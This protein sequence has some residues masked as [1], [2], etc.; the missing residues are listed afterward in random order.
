M[1]IDWVDAAQALMARSRRRAG[2]AVLLS[3][4]L[5][6]SVGAEVHAAD[7]PPG[8]SAG[9]TDQAARPAP[10]IGDES[11]DRMMRLVIKSRTSKVTE[12]NPNYEDIER[13]CYELRPGIAVSPVHVDGELV[14]V[15]EQQ[16]FVDRVERWLRQLEKTPAGQERIRRLGAAD[17]LSEARTWTAQGTPAEVNVIIEI[18]QGGAQP[19]AFDGVAARDFRGSGTW[20]SMANDDYLVGFRTADGTEF[21]TTKA[22]ALFHELGH[23]E[24][25]L[26]GAMT[27]DVVTYEIPDP[28]HEAEPNDPAGPGRR[29]IVES[30]EEVVT[31]G[32]ELGMA[33]AFGQQLVEEG[34][35][36]GTFTI[37][38]P[39][40]WEESLNYVDDILAQGE[41]Y[42]H[43]M[44]GVSQQRDLRMAVNSGPPLTDQVYAREA[45]VPV[46][47]HY[48]F[49]MEPDTD[50]MQ[51][52]RAF[53]P[54]EGKSEEDLTGD[55][56]RNPRERL[57]VVP[58]SEWGDEG[59]DSWGTGSEACGF[60]LMCRA[61]PAERG[62]TATEKALAR[63]FES[64]KKAGTV[65]L[66]SAAD[67]M[68][69]RFTPEELAA[70]A[71]VKVEG[72]V[73]SGRSFEPSY[74]KSL[75]E[76]D[77]VLLTSPE[78]AEKMNALGES[79]REQARGIATDP[80][81]V[82]ALI[83]SIGVAFVQDGSDL[84]KA[85]TALAPVPVV[86]SI[87]GIVGD[88]QNKRSGADIAANVLNLIGGVALLA[89]QPEISLVLLAVSMFVTVI[90]QIIAAG[91]NVGFKDEIERRNQGW[92]QELPAYLRATVVPATVKAINTLFERMQTRLLA[93]TLMSIAMV[94]TAASTHPDD[95][96]VQQKAQ[97]TV[98]SLRDT[99]NQQAAVLRT[100]FMSSVGPVLDRAVVDLNAEE[101][102]AKF[103]NE[104]LAANHQRLY[105]EAWNEARDCHRYPSQSLEDPCG[106]ESNDSIA[107]RQVD[108]IER[109]VRG[110]KPPAFVASDLDGVVTRA[111]VDNGLFQAQ[112]LGEDLTEAFSG[113]ALSAWIGHPDDRTRIA[114]L[115]AAQQGADARGKVTLQARAR[116]MTRHG[117]LRSMTDRQEALWHWSYANP[118]RVF[119]SGLPHA[120]SPITP[121]PTQS[122]DLLKYTHA[123]GSGLPDDR[124]GTTLIGA[125]RSVKSGGVERV[126]TPD[127][128][129]TSAD[130]FW[131]Y[132]IHAPG[133]ID[134]TRSI[135]GRSIEDRHE[136]VFFGGIKREYVRAAR[137]IGPDGKVKKIIT[138]PGFV[139]PPDRGI[140]PRLQCT[141]SA[142]VES[143][144]A[145]N[146]DLD[147]RLNDA[148]Y[149]A[150]GAMKPLNGGCGYTPSA[151]DGESGSRDAGGVGGSPE[152]P[153]VP[154]QSAKS[155]DSGGDRCTQGRGSNGIG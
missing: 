109:T 91:K 71:R 92:T 70:Y 114:Q 13:L 155:A 87:L 21:A 8:G 5:V 57:R 115:V 67:G 138:N 43:S 90:K 100:R 78:T 33:A 117:A 12:P 31:L 139:P 88:V 64:A 110:S 125:Y 84:D 119:A 51:I 44:E 120:R 94:E 35:A 113:D 36:P 53:A 86:G 17:P 151:A 52:V 54:P 10:R 28:L 34:A 89:G 97:Q 148:Y 37:K 63:E 143:G 16:A 50:P 73:R 150:P 48:T 128:A 83:G 62:L 27:N 19:F 116:V 102:V 40:S 69:L 134:Y 15:G 132:E 81:T 112:R 58:P 121:A 136:V 152:P 18:D 39:K 135:G 124:N 96:A 49:P 30:V 107:Q 85:T 98:K 42:P 145:N 105:D 41:D 6:I 123:R 25:A 26:Y 38:P 141:T 93:D 65:R 149:F 131:L 103:N 47:T 129:I 99:F 147:P 23:G 127:A 20:I 2:L 74:E 59:D 24:H 22:S 118:G 61:R 29:T 45:G 55:D 32:D 108:R 101:S 9:G 79:L 76:S 82:M 146:V 133:G 154:C 3:F 14:S 68:L 111:I 66:A 137:L 95:V 46:R 4:A 1:R 75:T 56:L 153:A 126:W 106:N 7:D 72:A 130:G 80:M 122:N 60:G 104:Y 142:P 140:L 11:D 77:R 144:Q